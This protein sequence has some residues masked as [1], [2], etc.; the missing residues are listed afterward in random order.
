MP[1]PP[2]SVPLAWTPEFSRDW[3]RQA[4]LREPQAPRQP[5]PA[6][7][8]LPPALQAPLPLAP[9][10]REE[11]ASPPP[12]RRQRGRRVVTR[13]LIISISEYSHRNDKRPDNCYCEWFHQGNSPVRVFSTAS[14]DPCP[15]RPGDGVAPLRRRINAPRPRSV[16]ATAIRPP[17]ARPKLQCALLP[18]CVIKTHDP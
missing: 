10:Q 5:G 6:L 13:P 15:A 18:P 2:P 8:P 17:R 14:P 4:Q 16:E 1:A 12:A 9:Q 3:R 11:R 7:A